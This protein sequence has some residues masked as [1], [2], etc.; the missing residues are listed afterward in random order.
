MTKQC[1]RRD[2]LRTTALFGIAGLGQATIL[3]ACAA[4]TTEA[5]AAEAPADTGEADVAEEATG[6][7]LSRAIFKGSSPLPV[8]AQRANSAR[9]HTPAHLAAD[10]KLQQQ[11]PIRGREA[12]ALNHMPE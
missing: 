12:V 4:P 10:E 3:S 6:R 9:R 11:A 5:P 7:F 1:T 2:F 8:L